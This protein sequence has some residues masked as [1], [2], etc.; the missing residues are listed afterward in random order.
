MEESGPGIVGVVAE[1]LSW[2][3]LPVAAA[4]ALVALILRLTRG[5]WDVAPAVLADGELR[6]MAA[7]TF[8][9]SPAPHGLTDPDED[10]EIYYRT[11]RPEVCYLER[12][13]HDERTMRV[14]ALCLGIV[15]II[16]VIVSTVAGA[17]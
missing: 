1:L 10:L 9:S 15:G 2:V 12:V 16:A 14:V 4:F 8:H 13:A 3:A 5:A 6:W 7:D 17:L 11:R